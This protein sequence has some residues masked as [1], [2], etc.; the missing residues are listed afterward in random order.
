MEI[1]NQE[2]NAKPY[3]SLA[4]RWRIV[5]FKELGYSGDEVSKIVPAF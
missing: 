1:E 4:D 5:H 3:L 2:T